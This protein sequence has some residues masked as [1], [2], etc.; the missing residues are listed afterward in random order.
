MKK[1]LKSSFLLSLYLSTAVQAVE[2]SI[3]DA[4]TELPQNISASFN[5]FYDLIQEHPK[6]SAIIAAIFYIFCKKFYQKSITQQS[7]NT[8]I[9]TPN[10]TYDNKNKTATITINGKSTPFSDTALATTST[11]NDIICITQNPNTIHYR[12]AAAKIALQDTLSL[13]DIM[14]TITSFIDS[15]SGNLIFKKENILGYQYNSDQTELLILT[16]NKVSFLTS[17]KNPIMCQLIDLKMGKEIPLPTNNE[18]IRSMFFDA[19]DTLIAINTDTSH[20]S[21]TRRT[22]KSWKNAIK[23]LTSRSP[24]EKNS[25]PVNIDQTY[26]IPHYDN[27]KLSITLINKKRSHVISDIQQYHFLTPTILSISQQSS[28]A[29][30]FFL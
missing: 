7:K 9:S 30:K 13:R 22:A 23:N 29:I 8:D 28:L 3:T 14:P 21:F 15:K 26:A 11:S 12:T 24:Y 6:L 19:N 16:F 2:F 1:A 20:E 10:I 17:H 25:T 18:Q 5:S 27:S 4:S